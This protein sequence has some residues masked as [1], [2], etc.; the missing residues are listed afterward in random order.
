[1]A[2]QKVA[3]ARL[4]SPGNR[5]YTSWDCLSK[6]PRTGKIRSGY[7]IRFIQ[8]KSKKQVSG[9]WSLRASAFL[10]FF[11]SVTMKRYPI[12]KEI[13]IL[14]RLTRDFLAE[15]KIP[16]FVGQQS[17]ICIFSGTQAKVS[18][19]ENLNV[20]L[21]GYQPGGG[22]CPKM[23]RKSLIHRVNI[24]YSVDFQVS[25]FFKTKFNFLQKAAWPFQTS[26]RALE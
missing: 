3:H 1:M 24:K 9:F 5:P 17:L 6:L 16:G 13:Y 25:P 7:I 18:R 21:K 4:C 23:Y 2:I 14:K 11:F 10:V 20:L 12:S 26:L 15:Y 22:E 19:T 8:F